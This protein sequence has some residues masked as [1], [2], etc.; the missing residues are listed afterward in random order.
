MS[1]RSIEAVLRLNTVDFDKDIAR[2]REALTTFRNSMTKMGRESSTVS[3]GIQT[4][5]S[6]LS[7]LLPILKSFTSLVSET[8]TFNAFSRGLPE[9]KDIYANI[10][11]Q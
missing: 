9:G 5:T 8:K 6:A 4:I 2:T 3:Q 10:C 11:E 1:G 7:S